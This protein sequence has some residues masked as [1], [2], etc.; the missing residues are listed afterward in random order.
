MASKIMHVVFKNSLSKLSF[1]VPLTGLERFDTMHLGLRRSYHMFSDLIADPQPQTDGLNNDP[2]KGLLKVPGVELPVDFQHFEHECFSHGFSS[3]TQSWR[4]TVKER[5]MMRIMNDLTDKLNWDHKVFNDY[6]MSKWKA[7][8]MTLTHGIITEKTWEWCSKELR[9]QAQEYRKNG[10]IKTLNSGQAI[11]KADCPWISNDV[12][13]QL[14]QATEPLLAVEDG[15]KDWHPGSN[16]K[17]LNLVHPSLYPFVHGRTKFLL[18]RNLGI[19]DCFDIQHAQTS[20]MISNEESVA[21]S[22][23]RY[24]TMSN[25]I[26]NFRSLWSTQ[27]Q[28]LPFDVNFI[29]QD[30]DAVQIATY[31]NNLHPTRYKELYKAIEILIEKSIQPWNSIL[32]IGYEHLNQN[33]IEY[34]QPADQEPE[35]P[36]WV[37][38]DRVG[39]G[40]YPDYQ[41]LGKTIQA[42]FALPD[43]PQ[44]YLTSGRTRMQPLELSF[45]GEWWKSI[46]WRII[47]NAAYDKHSRIRRTAH[48]EP[49]DNPTFEEWSKSSSQSVLGTERHGLQDRFRDYGLQVIAKLA[50]IELTP[51]KPEYSGGNWH[52]EGKLNE[53][54]VAT[55]I[56]YYDVHNITESRISFRQEANLDSSEMEY[57]HGEHGPILDVYGLDNLYDCPGVQ[58]VGSVVTREGRLLVFPNTLQHRVEP[59]RLQDSSKPGHRR[60]LVLWLVDP[61]YRILSTRNV[62]PQQLDW[63]TDVLAE[64]GMDAPEE[65]IE[66]LTGIRPM[67]KAEAERIRI[68][69]MKERTN[70]AETVERNFELYNFCEH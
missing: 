42:F 58:E 44:Y 4:N 24:N 33:R 52:L 51:E 70:A 50:S 13:Q 1:R 59:F 9:E 67:N 29:E 63:W 27:A 55:S 39:D 21:Q 36:D 31:I 2:R 48:P 10:F 69:L 47:E 30:K 62:P 56:Y 45:D 17:V 14:K 64:K 25:V 19:E 35:F 61:H 32:T 15:D 16:G 60:F 38:D 23:S 12:K 46:D 11:V 34:S 7:E 22:G 3:W 41:Q 49:G 54:I 43:N 26:N 68:E 20:T 28:W 65:N 5:T 37:H 8:A 57:D 6:V 66:S 40:T 18:N 53:H